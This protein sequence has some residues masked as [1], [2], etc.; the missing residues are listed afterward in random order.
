MGLQNRLAE[1][2]LEPLNQGANILDNEMNENSN[3]SNFITIYYIMEKV[4]KQCHG[5][6]KSLRGS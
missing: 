4:L 5:H 2:I 1:K 3:R 6:A